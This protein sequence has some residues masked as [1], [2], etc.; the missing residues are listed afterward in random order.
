[1]TIFIPVSAANAEKSTEAESELQ[2]T[3]AP[4]AEVFEKAGRKI[5]PPFSEWM[6]K[7]CARLKRKERGTFVEIW[8]NSISQDLQKC[9]L[10]KEDIEELKSVGKTLEYM[11][12]LD[13]YLEQLDDH[14]KR[15]KEEYRSKQKI[16][17]SMGIMGGIFLVILLL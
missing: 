17:Q 11:E 13:L 5:G 12:S 15:T 4:F 2:Y 10:R 16:C 7:L 9:G 3:K 14:I 1:M 6:L 8:C